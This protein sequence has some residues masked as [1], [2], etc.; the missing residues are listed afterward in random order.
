M[1]RSRFVSLLSGFVSAGLLCSGVPAGTPTRDQL[2][3][4]DYQKGRTSFLQRCS[5]CH[6]LADGGSNLVGPNL[7]GL[8]GRA[9]GSA[10]DF[11]ASSA[12]KSAGFPWSVARLAEFLAG[13]EQMVPG[14]RMQIPEP[15]PEAE[16]TALLAFLLL[17]TGGADWPKPA[18]ALLEQKIDR[19]RPLAE[20]YPSFYQHLMTNTTRYRME[21]PD[22]DVRF[23][24]YF[25]GDGSVS[26]SEKSMRGFW[27]TV[28]RKGMEFFCYALDG[29]PAKPSQLVECFPVAA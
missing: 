20:R 17:E 7:W 13:P 16:R 28:E 6:T 23:D 4:A 9:A 12:L 1:R 5:A 2:I 25:N 26:A 15:V 24:V 27:N 22:G 10:P 8:V 18:P 29:I 11:A 3:A 14:I 21:T 19:T